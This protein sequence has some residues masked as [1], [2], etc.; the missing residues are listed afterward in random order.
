MKIQQHIE[1]QEKALTAM[2]VIGLSKE[3]STYKAYSK[4]KKD[5]NAK[6]SI[7]PKLINNM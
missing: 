3:G 5:K 7:T 6:R 1:L 2:S 4:M